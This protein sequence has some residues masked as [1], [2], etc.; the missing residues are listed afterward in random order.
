MI[1]IIE[2]SGYL[3]ILIPIIFILFRLYYC[4]YLYNKRLIMEILI[5][6]LITSLIWLGFG[7]Y[8]KFKPLISQFVVIVSFYIIIL[9]SM[10]YMGH[11][12]EENNVSKK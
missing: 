3:S 9:L 12:L 4:T 6:S 8:K 7:V 10:Y 1:P 11:H 2:F 5:I